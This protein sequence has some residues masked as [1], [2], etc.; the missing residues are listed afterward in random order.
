[1]YRDYRI[2]KNPLVNLIYLPFIFKKEEIFTNLVKYK[3]TLLFSLLKEEKEK[4]RL[5]RHAWPCIPGDYVSL[6]YSLRMGTI[7]D[8]QV[9]KR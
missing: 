1:M 6:L 2:C 8:S 4:K 5:N 9:K 7:I 3:L